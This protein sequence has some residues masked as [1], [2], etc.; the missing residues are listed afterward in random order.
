MA[1]IVDFVLLNSYHEILGSNVLVTQVELTLSNNV[2]ILVID[3]ILVD[4]RPKIL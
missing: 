1:V 2:L 3:L 4:S